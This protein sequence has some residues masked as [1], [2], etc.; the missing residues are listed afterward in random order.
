M[1]LV[2]ASLVTLAT[3][4][5]LGA[6]VMAMAGLFYFFATDRAQAVQFGPKIIRVFETTQLIVGIVAVFWTVIWRLLACNR[7]KRV[8]LP[9]LLL[10]LAGAVVTT[11]FV[12]PRVN[13][14]WETGMGGSGEFWKWHGISQTIYLVEFVCLLV[15]VVLIPWSAAADRAAATPQTSPQT[16][17]A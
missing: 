16:A 1:K 13:Q 6:M 9:L 4:V 8:I 7:A 11:V 5:W 15:A 3:G 2:A 10:A 12:T 17:M 14:L